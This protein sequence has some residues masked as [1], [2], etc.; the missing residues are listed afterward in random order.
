MMRATPTN[1]ATARPPPRIT[2]ER[3]D[4]GCSRRSATYSDVAIANDCA[5]WPDRHDRLAVALLR[6]LSGALYPSGLLGSPYR[7]GR[8]R[9]A[10][11]VMIDATDD[12]LSVASR[13]TT[14]SLS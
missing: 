1:D 6:T 10:A 11:S 4:F 8:G 3:V 2:L 13:S 5:V 9:P 12:A 14:P 7:N